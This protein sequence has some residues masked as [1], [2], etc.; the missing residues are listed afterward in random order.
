MFM[1][2]LKKMKCKNLMGVA[3]LCKM[4]VSYLNSGGSPKGAYSISQNC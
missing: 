3:D 1:S 4:G 2:S